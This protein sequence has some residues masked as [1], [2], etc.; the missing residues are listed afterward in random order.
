[1]LVDANT[2]RQNTRGTKTMSNEERERLTTDSTESQLALRSP[3]ER[4]FYQFGLGG[5]AIGITFIIGVLGYAIYTR[6]GITLLGLFVGALLLTAIVPF[7][8]GRLIVR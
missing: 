5:L 8:V 6:G 1:M 2:Q 3:W 4:R 7:W